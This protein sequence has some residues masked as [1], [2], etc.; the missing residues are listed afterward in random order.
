MRWKPVKRNNDLFIRL[1]RRNNEHPDLRGTRHGLNWATVETTS[2]RAL[3]QK[4]RKG[5]KA[6]QQR[7]RQP[8]RSKSLLRAVP[9]LLLPCLPWPPPLPLRP[10]PL[11]PR[12]PRPPSRPPRPWLP[13]NT[14]PEVG[15]YLLQKHC[16]SIK[17]SSITSLYLQL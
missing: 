17:V 16:R 9:L 13:A 10:P 3:V 7:M 5:P 8:N 15:L 6:P 11:P 2:R 12:P 14:T 1:D 4:S